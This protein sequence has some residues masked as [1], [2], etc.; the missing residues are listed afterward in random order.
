MQKIKKA[1]KYFRH[2]PIY[3]A[4]VETIKSFVQ[5]LHLVIV[6]NNR[7]RLQIA[8]APTKQLDSDII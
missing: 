2:W 8:G 4:K 7:G 1:I 5:K 3:I 6:V